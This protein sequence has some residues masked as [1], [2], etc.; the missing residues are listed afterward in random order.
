M[1]SETSFE[2]PDQMAAAMNA[3][4]V[5]KQQREI[6]RLQRIENVAL[7]IASSRSSFIRSSSSGDKLLDDLDRALEAR[8]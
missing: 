1:V 6:V 3:E 5:A 4:T 8:P 7:R 2:N